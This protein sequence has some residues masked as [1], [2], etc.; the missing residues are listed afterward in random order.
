MV[1]EKCQQCQNLIPKEAPV[2]PNC[3]ASRATPTDE[4]PQSRALHSITYLV[5]RLLILAVL[6]FFLFR[7]VNKYRQGMQMP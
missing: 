3:G 4:W 5:I 6:A 7:M 1:L 2:C